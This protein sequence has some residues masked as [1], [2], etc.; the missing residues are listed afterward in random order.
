MRR[1]FVMLVFVALAGAAFPTE[2]AN[3]ASASPPDPSWQTDDIVR[4][5]AFGNGAIYL[6]GAFTHVRPPGADPGEKEV[7]RSHAAALNRTT[8]KLLKWNPNVDG[9]VFAIAVW[10]QRVILGGDFDSVRGKPRSNLAAV[11]AKTGALLKW[12][13]KTNGEVRALKLDG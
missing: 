3:A 2:A 7:A 13:P 6:G 10:R 8:G 1:T 9:V 5:I 4:A 12:S 11:D